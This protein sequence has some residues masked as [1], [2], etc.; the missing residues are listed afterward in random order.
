M[1]LADTTFLYLEQEES[2]E[3]CE[4][5]LEE[6]KESKEG[7]DWIRV[8][9]SGG[10]DYLAVQNTFLIQR[11]SQICTGE[12]AQLGNTILSTDIPLFIKFCCLK[13]HLT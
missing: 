3:I 5:E 6:L 1:T 11:N 10:T 4:S 7:R 2:V 8:L 12:R 9:L 13:I